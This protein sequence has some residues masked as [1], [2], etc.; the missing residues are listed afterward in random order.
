[1]NQLLQVAAIKQ[2]DPSSLR[3]A[4]GER[5]FRVEVDL[6]SRLNH[7]NLVR[8]IGYCADKS[9]RLLVYEYMNNGNLQDHLHGKQQIQQ[10]IYVSKNIILFYLFLDGVVVWNNTCFCYYE[11]LHSIFTIAGAIKDW[12]YA[13]PL[14]Y[15]LLYIHI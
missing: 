11:K 4:Q 7:P 9:Q 3:G 14:P 15:T 13:I 6:L 1:L 10:N 5:E 2:M 8:L 12:L